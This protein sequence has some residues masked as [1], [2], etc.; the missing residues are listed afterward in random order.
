MDPQYGQQPGGQQPGGQPYGAPPNYGQQPGYGQ[1]GAYSQPQYGQQPGYGQPNVGA[2]AAPPQAAPNRWGPTSIGM[3]ANIA[4]GLSYL[5]VI[6]GVIFFFV[7]KTNRFL[8][9]HCAQVILLAIAAVALGIVEGV[10]GTGLAIAAAASNSAG[11]GIIS[12]LFSC[13]FGLAYIGVLA[14]WIWGMISGFTGKYTKLPIIG[15]IAERWAG[16]APAPMF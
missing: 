3:D 2:Y 9:F 8:K 15:D 13:V 11:L 5:I 7:E 6:L 12:T 10:L 14:L 4:A 1:P 16:G